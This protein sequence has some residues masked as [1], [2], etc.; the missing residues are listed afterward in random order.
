MAH[1]DIKPENFLVDSDFKLKL[2]DFGLIA[3]KSREIKQI[4]TRT[5]MAPELFEKDKIGTSGDGAK[6]DT[7][8]L[9]LTL[10]VMYFGTLKIKKVPKES[11]SNL[12]R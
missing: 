10:F 8:A 11:I 6:I 5:Y 2:C 1:Y 12:E 7:C 9:G 4:G 3:P